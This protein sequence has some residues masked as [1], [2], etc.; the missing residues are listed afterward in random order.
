MAGADQSISAKT[1]LSRI[2]PAM[3]NALTTSARG[4]VW[5][6]WRL[7]FS[8]NPNRF[9]LGYRS[10][11]SLSSL[12]V[13]EVCER[14]CSAISAIRI[15]FPVAREPKIASSCFPLPV[16]RID[17]SYRLSR[18]FAAP[19]TESKRSTFRNSWMFVT[20]ADFWLPLTGGSPSGLASARPRSGSKAQ[21]SEVRRKFAG[22]C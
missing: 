22:N 7:A 11:S 13:S 20:T 5:K 17:D 12:R 15:V 8:P 9:K 4:N 6:C 18:I 10:T 1:T 3:I 16:L 2:V 19:V 21:G 14:K